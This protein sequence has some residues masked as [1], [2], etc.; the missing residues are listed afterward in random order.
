MKMEKYHLVQKTFTQ[1]Y[2][3]VYLTYEDKVDNY[4]TN[5]TFIVDTRER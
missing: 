1:E 2:I 5:I 4:T 3:L